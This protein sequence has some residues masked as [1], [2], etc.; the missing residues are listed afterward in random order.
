M[1][2]WTYNDGDSV[3]IHGACQNKVVLAFSI[4]TPSFLHYV[5]LH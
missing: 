4:N 2:V 1:N 3:Q 5:G